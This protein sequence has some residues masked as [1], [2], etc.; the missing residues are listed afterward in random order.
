[1][2]HLKEGDKAPD[3]DAVDH[4]GNKIKLENYRGKNQ[5]TYRTNT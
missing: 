3:I 1:M 5:V 4:K 2:A